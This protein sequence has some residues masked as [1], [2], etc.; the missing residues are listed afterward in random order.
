[1]GCSLLIFFNSALK[2][3]FLDNRDFW[4]I[5]TFRACGKCLAPLTLDLGLFERTLSW[6]SSPCE[7]ISNLQ[8]TTCPG[9]F[10]LRARR[11]HVR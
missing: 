9:E 5:V 6:D 10:G 1:M 8:R 11:S 2:F 4:F 3:I 7:M